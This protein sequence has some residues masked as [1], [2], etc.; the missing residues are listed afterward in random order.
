[1]WASGVLPIL[2][3]CVVCQEPTNWSSFGGDYWC[4]AHSDQRPRYDWELEPGEEPPTF[5]A[6][7][8]EQALHD[9]LTGVAARAKSDGAGE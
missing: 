2:N 8:F 9:V 7:E 6:A 4:E 1:M 3:L 5:T